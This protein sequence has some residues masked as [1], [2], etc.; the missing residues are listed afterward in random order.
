MQDTKK[1]IELCAKAINAFDFQWVENPSWEDGDYG[2]YADLGEGMLP[3]YPLHNKQLGFLIA[4]KLQMTVDFRRNLLIFEHPTESTVEMFVGFEE[5]A[6]LYC[7][8]QAAA[9]IG[10]YM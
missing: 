2:C 6:M 10:E 9:E 5:D 8:T 4:E 1:M 7:I 3:F